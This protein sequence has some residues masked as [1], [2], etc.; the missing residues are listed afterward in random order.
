M[1]NSAGSAP[2]SAFEAV[3][4]GQGAKPPQAVLPG[5]PTTGMARF[6]AVNPSRDFPRLGRSVGG[7]TGA[8]RERW[9]SADHQQM[10]PIGS[11]RPQDDGLFDVAGARRAGDHVHGAGQLAALPAN[12]GKGLFHGPHD[13]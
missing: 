13:T 11:V 2:A 4:Y 8:A 7:R 10:H 6:A 3:P 5:T 12:E 1:G 9:A